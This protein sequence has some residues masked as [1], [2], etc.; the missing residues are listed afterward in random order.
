MK[1]IVKSSLIV[2][3]LF[4]MMTPLAYAVEASVCRRDVDQML[5]QIHQYGSIT[6]ADGHRFD[7]IAHD[8][9]LGCFAKGYHYKEYVCTVAWAK[10]NWG[11]TLACV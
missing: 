11:K 6:A 9:Q 2:L 1:N 4:G 7:Q 3:F 10:G 8:D 5:V